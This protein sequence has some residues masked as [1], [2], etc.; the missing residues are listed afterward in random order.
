MRAA[1]ASPTEAN[2]IVATRSAADA[3]SG[4]LSFAYLWE[5]ERML[6]SLL[7]PQLMHIPNQLTNHKVTRTMEDQ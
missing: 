4:L 3:D 7:A 1:V 5:D 2:A 6:W